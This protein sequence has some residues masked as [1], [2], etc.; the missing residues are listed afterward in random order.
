M[1][2]IET[3]IFDL[4][5]VLYNINHSLTR[6]AILSL[7]SKPTPI[8]FSLT[9]QNEVFNLYESGRISSKEFRNELR[10]LF[11][12]SAT[13]NEIDTAWNSMLL[14][15]FPESVSIIQE[16]KS[17]YRIALLSNINDIHFRAIE[18]ECMPLFLELHDCFLSYTIGLRKPQP[19]IYNYVLNTMNIK[20][21]TTL[22]IDDAPQNINS[23]QNTGINT[24]HITANTPLMS[25]PYLIQKKSFHNL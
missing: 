6:Q 5:G 8:D 18:E 25:V 14:G 15:L 10:S 24:L 7:S 2:E 21:E 12:I 19:E 16:L 22:F 13:D 1:M 11:S 20:P 23:A 3:I 17:R 4:G 9:T